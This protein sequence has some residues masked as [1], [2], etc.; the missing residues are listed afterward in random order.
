MNPCLPKPAVRTVGRRLLPAAAAA[1]VLAFGA[2]PPASAAP[3]DNGT[4]KIHD[5][6]TSPNSTNDDPKV[7]QFHLAAFDFDT[8]ELVTWRIETQ[9]GDAVV[10]AGAVV[11]T[12]GSGATGTYALPDG[13]YKLYWNFVG[14]NG[15]AKQKVFKVE[16]TPSPSGTPTQFSNPPTTR[17][18]P[19]ATPSASLTPAPSS[20]PSA[21][22]SPSPTRT[23]KGDLPLGLPSGSPKPGP[24]GGVGTGGGG[25]SGPDTAEVLGGAVLLTAAAAFGVRLLR[26]RSSAGGES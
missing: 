24:V 8:V 18:S 23:P 25:T 17:P 13:Q 22:L 11:L 19:T 1:A 5:S 7:C 10:L 20:S 12:S 16:C 26:R 21:S 6:A 14:Q 15:A 4:V 9:P 3:G 2:V